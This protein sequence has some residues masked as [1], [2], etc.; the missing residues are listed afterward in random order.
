MKVKKT[1][2]VKP[3][4]NDFEISVITSPVPDGPD[5]C[6]QKT[7][8]FLR[9]VK[10]NVYGILRPAPSYMQSIFGGHHGVTRSLVEGLQKNGINFNYNPQSV[11]QLSRTVV[12]LADAVALK[13]M[14]L[15]KQ[16]GYIKY[17]LAGPNILN[18]PFSHNGILAAPE[19]DICITPS[20][21]VCRLHEK[22]LP[23]LSGRCLPWAAGVDTEFWKPQEGEARK[24]VL[25]YSKQNKGPTVSIDNY[26]A[27]LKK[28]G[29]DVTIVSYGSYNISEFRDLLKKTQ[30]MIGFSRDESQGIA[31]AEA[32]ACDVPT[33]IWQNSEQTYL[34]VQYNG[35]SAPYLCDDNGAFF[36]TTGDF[37]NLLDK[38]SHNKIQFQPRKWC[39]ENMSDEFC[40]NEL[41]R[42]AKLI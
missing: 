5:A 40:A 41:L 26:I 25:I 16:L 6:I 11:S 38:W 14:I 33:L 19:V 24:G 37:G 23:A 28:R 3:N 17:L 10:R 34:G 9:K 4:T 21:Q 12:V 36:S 30:L 2:W 1:A 31:W 18:D 20:E 42:L 35:S 7:K 39:L 15:F 22:F 32:W 8:S 27:E 29:L 13:Q